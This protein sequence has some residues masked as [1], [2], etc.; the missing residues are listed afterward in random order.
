MDF[1]NN[2]TSVSKRAVFNI[3][4]TA[5]LCTTL[6][7]NGKFC[8]G[9][10]FKLIEGIVRLE[11]ICVYWSRISFS[12]Y[13]LAIYIY[14]VL[15]SAQSSGKKNGNVTVKKYLKKS[16]LCILCF[17][18]Q[19][20]GRKVFVP[21]L[22]WEIYLHDTHNLFLFARTQFRPNERQENRDV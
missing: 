15:N 19:G 22:W 9:L 4:L 13:C 7:P 21:E 2:C 10:R 12:V 3:L 11:C 5:A 18:I 17:I 16:L 1:D 8:M 6:K 14:F 20:E